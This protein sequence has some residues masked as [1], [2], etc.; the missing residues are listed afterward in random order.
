MARTFD[1]F[2]KC[3]KRRHPVMVEKP[4][5][6]KEDKEDGVKTLLICGS[7]DWQDWDRFRNILDHFF[8]ER[9]TKFATQK[10]RWKIVHGACISGADKMAQK[11]A[12]LNKLQVESYPANW[13]KYGVAAGPIRNRVMIEESRPHAAIAFKQQ[14][15]S[16]GT[17]D[18]IRRLHEY[19]RIPHNRLWSIMVIGTHQIP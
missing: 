5:I 19:S 6:A 10:E 14:A 16:K 2:T 7:R 3:A 1:I 18:C 8:H 13:L 11:Y 4:K 17:D 12:E 9:H 15:T